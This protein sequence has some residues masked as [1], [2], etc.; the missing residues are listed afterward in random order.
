MRLALDSA[1]LMLRPQHGQVTLCLRAVPAGA[2]QEHVLGPHGCLACVDRALI[3]GY[4]C[5]CCGRLLT[6]P[7]M[8]DGLCLDCATTE[9]GQRYRADKA[10]RQERIA[11]QRGQRRKKRSPAESDT[12]P[13][14]PPTC[15]T[16]SQSSRLPCHRQRS[17]R[18]QEPA[19]RRWC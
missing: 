11:A 2:I 14:P 17:A 18:T 13:A 10:A 8:P 6:I 3:Q 12:P 19:S 15:S 4:I 16:T 7:V 1:P 9:A 5:P